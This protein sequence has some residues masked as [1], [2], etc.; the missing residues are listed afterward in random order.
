ML[1]NLMSNDQREEVKAVLAEL[2]D[3]VTRN[4]VLFYNVD[5]KKESEPVYYYGQITHIVHTG[6]V[7]VTLSFTMCP[8]HD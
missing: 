7:E 1:L 8:S 2:M 6:R 3:Q 4:D 5:L